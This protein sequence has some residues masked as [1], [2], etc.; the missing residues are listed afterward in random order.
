MIT[1]YLDLLF[2]W[3]NQ[4]T[5]FIFVFVILDALNLYRTLHSFFRVGWYKWF[6][7]NTLNMF[8]LLQRSCQAD[9]GQHGELAE[10]T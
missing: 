8:D 2:Q 10:L 5:F 9:F 3:K 6:H 7:Q 1:C 4:H